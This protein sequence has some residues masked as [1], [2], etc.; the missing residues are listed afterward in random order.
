MQ[1]NPSHDPL[2]PHAHEPNPRPPSD[3]PSFILVRPDGTEINLTVEALAALPR[4]TVADCYIVST[5]HGTSGPFT[6]TGVS[7]LDLLRSYLPPE[8]AWS[9]V[10][11]ISADGFGN[12][13][14]AGELYQPDP[15][16]PI[17][18]GYEID[19]KPL[20]REQGLVRMIAPVEKDDALRQVKWIGQ[21]RVRE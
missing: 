10:E 14:L 2:R 1:H 17:L 8:Q 6:F 9:Q 4:T 21:I 5:G 13:V 11:V 16:G 18:L 7:L 20:T 3:D 19:G 12:R 15:A